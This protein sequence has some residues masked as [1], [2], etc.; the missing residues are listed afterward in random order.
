MRTEPRRGEIGPWI[1]GCDVCQDA[2]PHNTNAWKD[3]EKFPGLEA[4]AGQSALEEIVLA[5]Y[6]WLRSAVQPKLWYIPKG[7]GVAVQN[8]R[9]QRHAEQRRSPIPAGH[10]EGV[11]G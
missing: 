7:E 1:F 9:A 6:D 2:C 4:W 5:D 10:P 8:E 11:R 3:T